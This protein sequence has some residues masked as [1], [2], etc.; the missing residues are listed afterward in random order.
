VA[1]DRAAIMTA[2]TEGRETSTIIA[3]GSGVL[4]RLSRGA[5]KRLDEGLEAGK[6][7]GRY[8]PT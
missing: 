6:R 1:G 4:D 7:P 8:L 3:M 5:W 2:A